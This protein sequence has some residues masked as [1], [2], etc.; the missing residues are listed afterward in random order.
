MSM[1]FDNDLSKDNIDFI[2]EMMGDELTAIDER[3]ALFESKVIQQKRMSEIANKVNQPV[4]V[5]IH[6]EGDTKIMEDGTKYKVTKEGWR[7]A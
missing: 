1:N 6:D 3:T 7:K 2:K 5:E 4:K